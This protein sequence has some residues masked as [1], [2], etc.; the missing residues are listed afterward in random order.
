MFEFKT[1]IIGGII[2]KQQ[3]IKALKSGNADNKLEKKHKTYRH[4]SQ[5]KS[6][7]HSITWYNIDILTHC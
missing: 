5:K 1:R 2:T 6:S 7:R 4:K 3:K